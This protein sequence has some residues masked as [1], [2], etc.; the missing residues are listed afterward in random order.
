MPDKGDQNGDSAK[1]GGKDKGE[2]KD[3]GKGKRKDTG[4]TRPTE[5]QLEMSAFPQRV[6]G[7]I[8]PG[9]NLVEIGVV[10]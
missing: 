10:H 1:G 6:N 2:G 3:K 5:P 4:K 7:V 8:V 9:G